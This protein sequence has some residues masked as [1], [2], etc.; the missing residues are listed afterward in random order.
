MQA[1]RKWATISLAIGLIYTVFTG[2]L[3]YWMYLGGPAL[4]ALAAFLV[5]VPIPIVGVH[6]GYR[7]HS[8]DSRSLVLSTTGLV[9]LYST[10]V[11]MPVVC[12]I[13]AN[14][15]ARHAGQSRS[16]R[17]NLKHLGSVFR[18]FANEHKGMFPPLS[19]A[20]GCLMWERNDVYPEYLEDPRELVCP[21][22][23]TERLRKFCPGALVDD[24]SYLY[25]GYALTND[26]EVECFCQAYRLYM[27][28]GKAFA[29]DIKVPAGKGTKGG[30]TIYRLREGIERVLITDINDPGSSQFSQ[31]S[32]PVLIERPRRPPFHDTAYANILFMDGHVEWRRYP[33]EWPMTVKTITALESL[34][35]LGK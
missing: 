16:C 6:R 5:S 28:K 12:F 8:G 23:L 17:N 25:L 21:S 1:L 27:A 7:P 33:G 14:S 31:S 9:L 15:I 35:F 18:S 32:L 24:Q 3:V 13:E 4:K 29:D 26:T 20:P 11:A 34:D 22:D 10:I 19:T 30:D 2:F